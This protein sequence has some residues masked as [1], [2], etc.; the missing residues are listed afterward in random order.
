MPGRLDQTPVPI[1]LSVEGGTMKGPICGVSGTEPCHYLTYGQ[2]LNLVSGGGG[3]G[4]FVPETRNVIAGAGLTGGGALS[5]DV[6][7][8]VGAGTGIL[9]GGSSVN[10][11]TA[12]GD[13]RYALSGTVAPHSLFGPS[14][15]DVVGSPISGQ[16]IAFDGTNWIPRPFPVG[17]DGGFVVAGSGVFATNPIRID[18]LAG[19][20]ILTSTSGV[21]LDLGYLDGRYEQSGTF[22]PVFAGS[23]LIQAGQDFHVQTGSGLYLQDDLVGADLNFLGTLY[24]ASGN[25]EL[26]GTADL[27]I[28]QHEAAADP[29]PQYLTSGEGNV[30]YALSGAGV[31]QA[32]G[33]GLVDAAG[34][35]HVQ[36]GSGLY[37]TDDLVG[38]N[39]QFTDTRYALSGANPP[40]AAGS[41]LITAGGAHHVQ[42]GSGLYLQDDLVGVDVAF[43]FTQFA[44]S[45]HQLEQH[46]NVQGVWT[47]G[48]IICYDGTNFVPCNDISGIAQIN[49]GSGLIRVNGTLHAQIGSGL[50]LTDDLLGVDFTQVQPSGDYVTQAEGD[51][52]Y[53]ASGFAYAAGS[54]LISAGENY[55]V[56]VGSGLYLTDDLVGFDT[57]FGDTRY[58]LSGI[59]NNPPA[60]SGLILNGGYHVQTGS[61]LY[62]QE[63]LVGA[64]IAFF[65]ARYAQS[66]V[67]PTV[68][69]GSGLIAVGETVHIQTGSGLYLQD[70]LVG[71]DIAFLSTLYAISGSAS[72]LAYTKQESDNRFLKLD[73]SNDPV[74]G[75]LEIQANLQ[76]VSGLFGNVAGGSYVELNSSGII[77]HGGA[78]EWQDLRV[79]PTA[80]RV[81]QHRVPDFA[82]LRGSVRTYCFDGDSKLQ[83]VYFEIALPHGVDTSQPLQPHVHF[84]PF[85]SGNDNVQWFLEYTIADTGSV[86]PST[87][88]VSGQETAGD[89]FEHRVCH[90]GEISLSGYNG[91]STAI[92]C[93]LYRDPTDGGD[94]FTEDAGF[95]FFN[96]HYLLRQIGSN[97]ELPTGHE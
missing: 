7:L 69:A 2:I 26:S 42:T 28:S 3:G 51:Q 9:I 62:L 41:G 31:P 15:S 93:R 89:A 60:G 30:L 24:A 4:P 76:A 13:G 40:S 27:R 86:L 85:V 10:F 17:G 22:E 81:G 77:L 54:G 44:A 8:T 71:V 70:D 78:R 21:Y 84:A 65:D 56:Q 97:E 6:T 52:L 87:V 73:A 94:T 25:F 46:G 50:Y 38:L 33:S 90:L 12:F 29:H 67:S 68:H 80:V 32:A 35:R 1:F 75:D 82:D 63:D 16:I 88:T 48:Q 23:G 37:L 58:A 61:G 11:D 36:V 55:H 18:I 5:A 79:T 95:L 64:D 66:G 91:N 53:A 19:V 74:T 43:L 57:G 20:G 49:A 59:G 96:V 39:V 47:S 45:G 14:H 83:Q 92:M 72:G 34:S